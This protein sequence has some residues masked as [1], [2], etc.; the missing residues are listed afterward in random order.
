MPTAAVC[1]HNRQGQRHGSP[2]DP[3]GQ[4]DGVCLRVSERSP[5]SVK[6]TV[7]TAGKEVR[8]FGEEMY[9][10]PDFDIFVGHKEKN[11]LASWKHLQTYLGL[12]AS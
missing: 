2:E 4:A 11:K 10:F 3:G 6:V 5:F 8:G 9:P 7:R 1:D 12:M